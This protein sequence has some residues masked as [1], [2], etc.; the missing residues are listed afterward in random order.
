MHL[1]NTIIPSNNPFNEDTIIE[2]EL[3]D[4]QFIIFE[5]F[6]N[7]KNVL[8]KLHTLN[9]CQDLPKEIVQS[10]IHTVGKKIEEEMMEKVFTEI[11]YLTDMWFTD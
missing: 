11:S 10:Y 9:I 1:I 7:Y 4:I 6:Q 3:T 2:I 5:K 8:A